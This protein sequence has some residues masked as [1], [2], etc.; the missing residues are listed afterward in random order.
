MTI[1]EHEY[2]NSAIDAGTY[3]S[4]TNPDGD[5]IGDWCATLVDSSGFYIGGYYAYCPPGG[6]DQYLP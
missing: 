6:C 2:I 4:C 3:S 1:V 5:V